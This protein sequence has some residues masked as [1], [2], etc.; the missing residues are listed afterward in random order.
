MRRKSIKTNAAAEANLA[1][2]LD[3]R[4][5]AI[6]RGSP[7]FEASSVEAEQ[8]MTEAK[9]A[10]FE[11]IAREILKIETLKTRRS[12]SLDFHDVSVWSL[13]EALNRAYELGRRQR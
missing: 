6:E 3:N 2:P 7:H 4:D 10:M 12:D 1:A 13:R 11:T 5:Y 9:L 8:S